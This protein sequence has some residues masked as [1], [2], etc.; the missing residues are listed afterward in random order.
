MR[1]RH[2]VGG[3]AVAMVATCGVPAAASATT[4]TTPPRP[5]PGTAQWQQAPAAGSDA[6]ASKVPWKRYRTKP[7]HDAPGKVC[8]FGVNATIVREREQFRTL[9]SYPDGRP[10]LQEFRGPLFVRYTN[11]STGKSVVGNLSGYGWFYYPVGG[12]S[13]AFAPSHIGV[14]VPAGNRGFP[15][16][17]WIVSGRSLLIVGSTGAISIV[18]IHATTQNICRTLS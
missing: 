16:G 8:A 4:V 2:I 1:F 17:E 15:A 5:L 6:A 7:W 14:T 18:L 10:R 13:D 9:S 3:L 11:A 12:G